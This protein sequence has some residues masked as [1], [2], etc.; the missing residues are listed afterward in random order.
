[1]VLLRRGDESALAETISGHYQA[2]L[3]RRR[4]P[5]KTV[6]SLELATFEG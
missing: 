3:I 5:W 1:M 6:E 4:A 2:E